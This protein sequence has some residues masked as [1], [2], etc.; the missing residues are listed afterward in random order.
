MEAYRFVFE[1]RHIIAM[2][3]RPKRLPIMVQFERYLMELLYLVK[4]LSAQA[5]NLSS[6]FHMSRVA[7]GEY[8]SPR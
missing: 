1:Y 8:N 6:L 7:A 3:N 5:L 4:I 2:G